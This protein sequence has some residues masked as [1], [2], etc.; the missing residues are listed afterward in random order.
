MIVNVVWGGLPEIASVVTKPMCGDSTG[1]IILNVTGATPPYT[2]NWTNGAITPSLNNIPAGIYNVTVTDSNG[3]FKYLGFALLD[4]LAVYTTKTVTHT[5]CGLNNGAVAIVPSGS[6]APYTYAWT[7][8]GQNTA[9][10]IN[11]APGTHYCTTTAANGCSKK[12]TFIIISS[13]ATINVLSKANANCDSSNGVVYV[14]SVQNAI[15]PF[16][17]LWSNA[18][19]GNVITSLPAGNYWVQTTDAIGCIAVDSFYL[20]NDGKPKLNILAYTP[21]NCFGDSTG[22]VT[23]SGSNGVPPYKY[24]L[25]GINYFSFAQIDSI[26]GGTYPVYIS[27]AN[28]CLNDTILTFAQPEKIEVTYLADSVVCF[29]DK[30]AS[31]SITATGGFVP[32]SY[33]FNN[34]AFSNQM[35]YT[36]L[37][38]GDYPLTVKDSHNCEEEFLV[39]IIGPEDSLHAVIVKKDVPCFEKNTGAITISLEGGWPPYQYTWSNPNFVGLAFVNIG[40]TH[41]SIQVID[42]KGCEINTPI[43][44]EQLLCCKMVIPNAFTPNGDARNDVLNVLPISE[45]STVKLTIVNRWGQVMFSTK[46][47]HDAWDGKFKGVD[48]DV[49]TYFYILEYTCPFQKDKVVVKG[50]ITLIR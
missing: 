37:G 21:P 20:A 32:Y 42:D 29:H 38:K 2:Y 33:A 23:L 7:P 15:L 35:V 12:D 18:S 40:E 22:S 13:L 5:K 46:T 30:T 17:T 34:V 44:V 10:A 14:L 11:L 50:D 8:S 19:V 39:K 24:S 25:D 43:N 41:E 1:S 26:P 16:T 36:N 3:C 4:T 45:V 31:L 47:I 49:D 48:C 27:D 6:I 9:T 28:S